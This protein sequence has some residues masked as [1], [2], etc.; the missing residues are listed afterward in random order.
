MLPYIVP[1]FVFNIHILCFILSS[2]ILFSA[3]LLFLSFRAIAVLAF[4]WPGVRFGDRIPVMAWFSARAHP[5]SHKMGTGSLFPGAKRPGC[6][7]DHS[8]QFSPKVP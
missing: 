1:I 7:V 2:L 5:A 6:G 8:P 4:T 3:P